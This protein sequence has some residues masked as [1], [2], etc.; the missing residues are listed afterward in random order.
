MDRSHGGSKRIPTAG[1]GAPISVWWDY[2]RPEI[3]EGR[4]D[5]AHEYEYADSRS[6]SHNGNYRTPSLPSP[7]NPASLSTWNP[8]ANNAALWDF[9]PNRSDSARVSSRRWRDR[10]FPTTDLALEIAGTVIR[11]CF[12]L[13]APRPSYGCRL[14]VSA[15]RAIQ[16]RGYPRSFADARYHVRYRRIEFL[17]RP[18]FRISEATPAM[19]SNRS[20]TE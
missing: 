4:P 9:A 16:T 14:R 12:A 7:G 11:R 13:Y 6:H 5:H 10:G 20:W 15:Q 18:Q 17:S 8:A 19:L 2:P 1:Q 3:H